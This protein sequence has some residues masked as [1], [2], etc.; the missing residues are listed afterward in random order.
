MI[1]LASVLLIVGVAAKLA[2]VWTISIVVLPIGLVLALLGAARRSAA[3]AAGDCASSLTIRVVTV[4]GADHGDRPA[5]A[6][7]VFQTA[8]ADDGRVDLKISGDLDITTVPV[9]TDQL[10]TLAD[11]RPAGLVIDLSR[12]TFLDCASARLLAGMAALLPP[13][14]H[15]SSPRSGR[16]C[17]ACSSSS[18]CPGVCGSRTEATHEV[19]PHARPT[20]SGTPRGSTSRQPAA[21]R[22]PAAI[23]E[24]HGR[25]PAASRCTARVLSAIGEA[26]GASQDRRTA[27]LSNH[28]SWSPAVPPPPVA[29]ATVG[30]RAVSVSGPATRRSLALGFALGL[31]LA[32]A[33]GDELPT[34]RC[35]R[36]RRLDR[37]RMARRGRCRCRGRRLPVTAS[38]TL[39]SAAIPCR[40]RPTRRRPSSGPR[41]RRRSAPH[42]MPFQRW[43]CASSSGSSAGCVGQRQFPKA[44]R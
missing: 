32:P 3:A 33:A 20:G 41:S 11:L 8:V 30:T 19:T 14:S 26:A 40:P 34:R 28:A 43:R 27:R 9:L 16:P 1:I 35:R 18:G 37:G 36:A 2:L 24:Q 25:S 6:P 13:A 39:P 4:A 44:Q 17:G 12:V 42:V 38:A 22:P 21:G 10:A 15:R 31:R 7:A 29:G 5:A 23:T